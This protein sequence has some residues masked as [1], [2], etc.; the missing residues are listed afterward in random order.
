[1]QQASRIVEWLVLC[2]RSDVKESDVSKC[3]KERLEREHEGKGQRA[4]RTCMKTPR[5]QPLIVAGLDRAMVHS[6]PA[7]AL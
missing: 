6:P 4:K 5:V 2:S 3:R 1:M 7:W